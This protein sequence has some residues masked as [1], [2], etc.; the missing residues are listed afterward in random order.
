MAFPVGSARAVHALFVR[1]DTVYR[2]LGLE[3]WDEARDARTYVPGDAALI[4]HPPCRTWG[5]VRHFP[6]AR[7]RPEERALG[8][9][10]VDIV[11]RAGGVLEHPFQ[12]ALWPFCGLPQPGGVRLHL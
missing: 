9:L 7:Q 12:S 3:C 6:G 2:H 11:R 1:S 10:A 8:P 5:I 4:C